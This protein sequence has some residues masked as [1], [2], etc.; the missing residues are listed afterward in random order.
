MVTK[1]SAR[2]RRYLP[3]GTVNDCGEGRRPQPHRGTRIPATAAGACS[4]LLLLMLY[5]RSQ[6]GAAKAGSP[7]PP[8]SSLASPKIKRTRPSKV[9]AS[10]APAGARQIGQPRA[11]AGLVCG[12]RR[13]TAS[14][15]CARRPHFPTGGHDASVAVVPTPSLTQ[16]VAQAANRASDG[17]RPRSSSEGAKRELTVSEVVPKPSGIHSVRTYR[18]RRCPGRGRC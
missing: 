8:S 15:C 9:E 13:G 4:A 18:R 17:Q 5:R 1:P 11:V 6:R 7:L 12:R 2:C 10:S 14:A 3:A 16:R